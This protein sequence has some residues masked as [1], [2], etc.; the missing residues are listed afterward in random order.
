MDHSPRC[1]TDT[2]DGG[3]VM[4][5]SACVGPPF[6]IPWFVSWPLRRYFETSPWCLN[7]TFLSSRQ[8]FELAD[9]ALPCRKKR[10]SLFPSSLLYKQQYTPKLKKGQIFGSNGL[11]YKF[12]G[13]TFSPLL[14]ALLLSYKTFIESEAP[15]EKLWKPKGSIDDAL[16]T[17]VHWR[18]VQ[19]HTNIFPSAIDQL[20]ILRYNGNGMG[21]ASCS[22]V[23]P[24]CF[25]V[26][27]SFLYPLR[28]A[29]I[30][31]Q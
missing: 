14:S 10:D 16:P 22:A 31:G 9:P 11:A 27:C 15:K 8:Y 30:W 12:F 18:I 6:L 21:S 1:A 29:W 19:H 24:S 3:A 4:Q 25:L 2:S 20:Q 26:A 5:V 7:R 17:Q 13:V 23:R 28:N